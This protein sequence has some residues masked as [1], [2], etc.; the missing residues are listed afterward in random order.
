[1]ALPQ[2]FLN[3]YGQT[4]T[5][6]GSSG[7]TGPVTPF[8]P[9]A[10]QA[11]DPNATDP[12]A[13]P[14]AGQTTQPQGAGQG[15]ALGA[16]PGAGAGASSGMAGMGASQSN[17]FALSQAMGIMQ[18]QITNNNGL[19][20][21]KN[22][23]LQQLYGVPLTDA[24][25]A[26]MDPSLASV[27]NS[28]DRNAIDFNLRL[29]NDQI[30]GRTN[31]LDQSISTLTTGYNTAVQQAE[32]DKNDAVTNVLNYAKANGQKPSVIMQALYP[33]YAQQLGPMLDQIAAPYGAYIPPAA[34]S[35]GITSLGSLL[36]YYTQGNASTTPGDGYTG[37]ILQQLQGTGV[38]LNSSPD[39]LMGY[40]PQI[41]QGIANGENISPALLAATNNPGAIEQATAEMYGLP[42]TANGYTDSNGTTYAQFA[43]KDTGMQALQTLV[44]NYLQTGATPIDAAPP[45]P[46]DP[47][48]NTIDPTTGL[49]A[50]SIY[51]NA[52]EYAFTGK[53]PALG[54][55]NAT[56]TR[57]AR[58]AIQNKA[59]AIAAAAGQTFPQL[60]ALYK[61]NETAATQTVERLARVES[62]S[63]AM[64]LNIPRLMTLADQVKA[65]GID[66]TEADLQSSAA[67][68]ESKFGSGP[69]ASYIELINTMRSDYSAMQS[70]LAGSRGGQFFAAQAADAIP[71]GLSSEQYK[72]IG[73]TIQLSSQNATQ[74]INGETQTLLGISGGLGAQV[75]GGT[76]GASGSSSDYQAYLKA[77]Q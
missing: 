53:T 45:D 2:Q 70:G 3:Q 40:I 50:N 16:T 33:Q 41:A 39:Q 60:Q 20:D 72:A 51:E 11:T 47:K 6:D 34:G 65:E 22:L 66:I 43:D 69:A 7:A 62:V 12:N 55:G 28:G 61:S 29:L 10:P 77:I 24:Q 36:G 59:G 68:I 44:G 54:L 1:M 21:Q 52:I 76:S 25:K 13:N 14:P 42:T 5:D 75:P 8:G 32:T 23:M 38:T 57:A 67:T 58:D 49:S 56:Q 31:T 4:I 48:S 26:T 74:A 63:Q 73:D 37:A 15:S 27:L 64:T 30:A 17:P 35:T 19:V 46:K 9:D 18:G 71:I